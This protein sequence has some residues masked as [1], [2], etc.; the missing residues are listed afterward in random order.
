MD[1]SHGEFRLAFQHKNSSGHPLPEGTKPWLPGVIIGKC[2]DYADLIGYR[3]TKVIYLYRGIRMQ[4]VARRG[5]TLEQNLEYSKENFLKDWRFLC[6]IMH[7]N[8]RQGNMTLLYDGRRSHDESERS[9]TLALAW[10]LYDWT[11]DPL[12]G[13]EFTNLDMVLRFLDYGYYKEHLEVWNEMLAVKNWK[14]GEAIY[15]EWKRNNF[16]SQE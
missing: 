7:D 16:S 2:D 10:Y 4:D 9:R 1:S 3:V 14:K 5:F 11:L 15:E 6:E 13:Q 8:H 12:T